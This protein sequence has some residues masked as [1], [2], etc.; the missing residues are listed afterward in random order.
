MALGHYYRVVTDD[1]GNVVPNVNIELRRETTG[2]PLGNPYSD[3]DGD[4]P[5]GNPFF[6]ADGVIDIFAVGFYYSVRAYGAGF[7][8][9]WRYEAIGTA[10][11]TDI[12]TLNLPG[13]IFE[14][15]TATTSPPSDGCIRANNTDL[16]LATRLYVSAQ[17][18]AGV[19][20]SARILDMVGRR[21]LISSA[22]AGEQV[23]W[24]VPSLTDHTTWIEQVLTDHAGSTAVPAGRCGYQR[25]SA[26]GAAGADGVL[27]ADEVILTGSSETLLASQRGKTVL[28]NRATSMALAVEAAATLGANYMVVLKNIGAGTV[29]LD[30]DGS[31][32]VD[33]AATLTIPPGASCLL[34]GN[35]TLLRTELRSGF[36]IP[37][38]APGVDSLAGYDVSA[39]AGAYFT[40][41]KGLS[42]SGT[43]IKALRTP[44][45]I[46]SSGTPAPDA[47]AYEQFNITALAQAAAIGAPTGT[48]EGGQ[49]LII[50][51]KDNGTARALTWNAIYR[52]VGGTL[53]TTTVLGKTMYVGFIYNA[54][55]SKWDCVAVSTEA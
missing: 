29:T 12:D 34:S 38:T 35:G 23:S 26:E 45:A 39:G 31:E 3:V 14:F 54:T 15:E 36:D 42:I 2:S 22:A 6:C 1:A 52:S 40:P 9:T 47:D 10:Q 55:D 16:S 51:I 49:K 28:L 27:S 19:D 33:G 48:P 11:A 32:T 43:T 13:Y 41:G 25:E 30:P 4:V 24:E 37:T 20:A 46:T 17:T 44:G 50:R 8:K 53:P 21:A 5:L 7:D 18:I